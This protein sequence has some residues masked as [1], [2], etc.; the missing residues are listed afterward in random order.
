MEENEVGIYKIR[1]SI[2]SSS[3][4]EIIDP[5]EL[6]D[7]LFDA[8]ADVEERKEAE[9]KSVTSDVESDLTTSQ[10]SQVVF[11]DV[12]DVYPNNED[13]VV[14]FDVLSGED[15]EK[16]KVGIFKTPYLDPTEF[17]V[18][19]WGEGGEAKFDAKYLP[20]ETDFY[21]FQYITKDGRIT[22]ASIPWQL[23]VIPGTE[24]ITAEVQGR[25]FD[26]VEQFD[27]AL[28]E[29]EAEVLAEKAEIVKEKADVVEEKAKVAEE[30]KIVEKNS[31]E[32]KEKSDVE[33]GDALNDVEHKET[34]KDRIKKILSQLTGAKSTLSNLAVA[35]QIKELEI[36][37]E[38]ELAELVET[39]IKFIKPE[40]FS[41]F[42]DLCK[43]LKNMKIP[44]GISFGQIL[45]KYELEPEFVNLLVDNGLLST[46][47]NSSTVESDDIEDEFVMANDEEGSGEA[48]ETG[49]TVGNQKEDPKKIETSKEVLVNPSSDDQSL[50]FVFSTLGARLES[51]EKLFVEKTSEFEQLK[52]S[53][54]DQ[55]VKHSEEADSL[56]A[57]LEELEVVKQELEVQVFSLQEEKRSILAS[58]ED[59]ESSIVVLEDEYRSMLTKLTAL[60]E[61]EKIKEQK[62]IENSL[63]RS[64]E[65]IN[66]TN[67]RLNQ[68][69]EAALS[70]RDKLQKTSE[71]LERSERE[72]LRLEAELQM[73]RKQ[74][75]EE[76]R[77][78]N[79][80]KEEELI[81]IQME[82]EIQRSEKSE[83]LNKL[84]QE[85]NK[86]ES[87]LDAR[88]ELIKEIISLKSG[89]E[90]LENELKEANLML[91]AAQSSKETA[92]LEIIQLERRI[93][94]LNSIKEE[95]QLQRSVG[96]ENQPQTKSGVRG[97][98][99]VDTALVGV[100][101]SLGSRLEA[102]TSRIKELEEQKLLSRDESL[103]IHEAALKDADHNVQKLTVLNQKLEEDKLQLLKEKLEVE[104]NLE[105]KE[106]ENK[107]LR[108]RLQ[109][110]HTMYGRVSKEKKEKAEEIRRLNSL[111]VNLK[112]EI[113]ILKV[114]RGLPH[115]ITE[116]ESVNTAT[117]PKYIVSAALAR[118]VGEQK[119]SRDEISRRI[120]NYLRSNDLLDETKTFFNP[121]SNLVDVFGWERRNVH[122]M[123]DFIS[124]HITEYTGTVTPT[125]ESFAN[126]SFS[127][128]YSGSNYS[129]SNLDSFRIEEQ[130]LVSSKSAV[131]PTV[132]LEN[133][134][135]KP[136]HPSLISS[137]R[138]ELPTPLEPEKMDCSPGIPE[139]RA[140]SPA[141]YSSGEMKEE[142]QCPVCKL[143]FKDI[144]G[145]DPVYLKHIEDHML[146]ECPICFKTFQAGQE[147]KLE[148]HVNTHFKDDDGVLNWDL[149]I[150]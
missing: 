118:I 124:A 8:S 121:D 30:E 52:I 145:N 142:L 97:E 92:G 43:L 129:N 39:V 66:T 70:S 24:N 80:E 46:D 141:R 139:L 85:I 90:I 147:K 36:R 134:G 104:E 60:E 65:L 14:R 50:V 55:A 119:I 136:K 71:D 12:L 28:V 84:M 9:S 6:E 132:E 33:K 98:V 69:E 68:M 58:L 148:K 15:E 73:T 7:Q 74:G 57:K 109:T 27:V 135:A 131:S 114:E 91:E 127:S 86:R 40:I 76:K 77:K 88:D 3:S 51:A 101:T 96:D 106:A 81:K 107:D 37:T 100:L 11:N 13:I 38:D 123:G 120:L 23:E 87:L 4:L 16:G 95:S 29:R 17:L 5:K 45:Q 133:T 44:S 89:K 149:G 34:K 2:G 115:L 82:L 122:K 59:K 21:Q 19:A 48:S 61:I 105:N 102:A 18:F 144:T 42:A 10:Y 72:R 94:E 110:G 25:G 108:T 126:S 75:D 1:G 22:G 140:R 128:M 125:D 112:S 41:N 150:D 83:L 111:I 63:Q 54:Q 137:K 20:S 31:E 64:E 56:K 117:E 138:D 47:P 67:I 116:N 146:P 26:R 103:E 35:E 32:V 62:L 143:Q 78:L 130:L 79:K 49:G 53:L 113:E 93:Q 99:E